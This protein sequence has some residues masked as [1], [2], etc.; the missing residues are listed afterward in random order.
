LRQ[1]ERVT[2]RMVTGAV[3]VVAGVVLIA[4]AV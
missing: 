1:I 2:P 3:L 4:I